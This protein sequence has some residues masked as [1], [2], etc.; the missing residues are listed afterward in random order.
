MKMIVI[1]MNI[2]LYCN[3]LCKSSYNKKKIF[4]F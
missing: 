2:Y 1:E 3:W 4:Y